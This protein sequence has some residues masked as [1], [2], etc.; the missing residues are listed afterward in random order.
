MHRHPVMFR[1][2]FAAVSRAANQTQVRLLVSG[3]RLRVE[4][5][6]WNRSPVIDCS[7]D[8]R[9]VDSDFHSQALQ[10]VVG[11]SL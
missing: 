6:F 4:A 10:V 11:I 1:V 5:Y 8:C 2:M 9:L 3:A 7:S